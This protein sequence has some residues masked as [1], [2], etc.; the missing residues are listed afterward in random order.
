MNRSIHFR[1]SDNWYQ[2]ALARAKELGINLSEYIRSVVSKDCEELRMRREKFIKEYTEGIDDY[3]YTLSQKERK[4]IKKFIWDYEIDLDINPDVNMFD[5]FGPKLEMLPIDRPLS[6]T[7]EEE[8]DKMIEDRIRELKKN[9]KKEIWVL[10][11]PDSELWN[12]ETAREELERLS[13]KWWIKIAP[14]SE[15][16]DEGHGQERLF[17]VS[18]DPEAVKEFEKELELGLY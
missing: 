14:T 17:V 10:M 7:M 2:L 8:I 12:E 18:G 11:S 1:V 13:K 5:I 4:E 3:F 9:Y 15:T 6:P 16:R